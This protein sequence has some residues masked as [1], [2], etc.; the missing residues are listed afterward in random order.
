MPKP[1][2][3]P[4]PSV[5]L[6]RL[7]RI[8]PGNDVWELV[9][10]RGPQWIVSK[11]PSVPPELPFI[12]ICRSRATGELVM[13]TPAVPL[14]G[15]AP[16]VSLALGALAEQARSPGSNGHPGRPKVVEVA[17]AA[18]HAAL[19]PP[20]GE[21]GIEVDLLERIDE[22]DLVVSM[23]RK[24]LGGPLFSH[25]IFAPDVEPERITAFAEA[26]GAFHAA[27]PWNQLSDR[28]L[29][30]ITSRG[31]PEAMKHF[32][33]LGCAGRE[34]GI[35]FYHDVADF[36]VVVASGGKPPARWLKRERWLLTFERAYRVPLALLETWERQ[37]LPFT[38]D[39]RLPFLLGLE[40]KGAFLP[41]DAARLDFLESLLRALA[42]TTEDE[43]DSGR[44][45]HAVRVA[46]RARTLT[47]ELPEILAAESLPK[48][49][50]LGGVAGALPD[51]RVMERQME[52]IGR[53]LTDEGLSVAELNARL[54]ASGG[55]LPA[56]PV[57]TDAVGRAKELYYAALEAHGRLR[58]KLAR[59]AVR[60][61]PDCA[62]AL[63]LLGEGMPDAKRARAF[64]EQ[65]VAAAERL[66]GP[67][68]FDELR[69]KFWGVFETRPYVRARAALA[70][71]VWDTG[72][73]VLAIDHWLAL[74][75]LD[76]GDHR[77]V[78]SLLVPRLLELGR[79][80]EARA[81][82]A[83]FPDDRDAL[84]LYGDALAAYRLHGPGSADATAALARAVR[85]NPHVVKYL[86]DP[87]RLPAVTSRGY[88]LG[89]ESEAALAVPMLI[90]A[91]DAT[92]GAEDWLRA[93]RREKKKVREKR[94]K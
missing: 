58:I 39:D 32:S 46:G 55:A 53:M 71:T 20:L 52:Q 18:L 14:P 29:V 67:K 7:R 81:V 56:E 26:A 27:A 25:E 69:G 74:L 78:R 8:A 13:S 31:G 47:F 19:V 76:E 50:R 3:P 28:D 68:A 75:D 92:P 38:T 9:V 88:T 63:V 4:P 94:R 48:G 79:A 83:R 37:G 59:E 35:G 54:A 2:S 60:L 64:F 11:D 36:E 12:G 70:E 34:F 5:D 42:V 80:A 66:L 21:L 40:S 33:I 6:E 73:H 85:S 84:L 61:W 90:D 22:L 44:W 77:G 43:L 30:R 16:Y 62:D 17:D 57:A 89:S 10:V 41:V 82:A 1:V 72:D 65:A 45:S 24:E 51:R 93:H 15:D 91:W 86:L 23:M 49:R 87:S